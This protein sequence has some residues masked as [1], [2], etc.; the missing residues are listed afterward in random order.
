MGLQDEGGLKLLAMENVDSLSE[1]RKFRI[2]Q[3]R[4]HGRL[5]AGEMMLDGSVGGR[6]V[7]TK[8]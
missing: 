6:F 3:T 1:V 5:R 4:R 8:L 7:Y 2:G